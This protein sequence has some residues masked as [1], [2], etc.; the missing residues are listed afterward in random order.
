M[1]GFYAYRPNRGRRCTV[2]EATRS[3]PPVRLGGPLGNALQWSVDLFQIAREF[4]L[5][6]LG[7]LNLPPVSI[8]LSPYCPNASAIRTHD[9][10]S[11][12]WNPDFLAARSDFEVRV[13][14]AH[15][16]GHIYNWLI[17]TIEPLHERLSD[18]VAGW[19]SRRAGLMLPN[20]ADLGPLAQVLGLLPVGDYRAGSMRLRD[21]LQGWTHG[22]DPQPP[23]WLVG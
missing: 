12:E 20:P 11:L 5:W 1:G 19:L 4:A 13:I 8:A 22:E 23:M 14:T 15:E 9:G 10:F 7:Q 17:G 21:L 16:V 6:G 18:V 3:L 2:G